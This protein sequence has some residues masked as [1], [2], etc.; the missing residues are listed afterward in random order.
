MWLRGAVRSYFLCFS[1][2]WVGVIFFLFCA[3]GTFFFLGCG[4]GNNFFLLDGCGEMDF[5][6]NATIFVVRFQGC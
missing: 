3:V 2:L 6:I 4:Y 5:V 1:L